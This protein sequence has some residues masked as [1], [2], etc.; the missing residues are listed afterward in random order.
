MSRRM[1]RERIHMTM[2][3]RTIGSSKKD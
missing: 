3:S 2:S 1:R